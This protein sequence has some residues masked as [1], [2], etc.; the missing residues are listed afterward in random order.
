MIATSHHVM[1]HFG[2]RQVHVH[3]SSKSSSQ[4][5]PISG[6][7]ASSINKFVVI[8]I[9][10][11]LPFVANCGMVASSRSI[12][13]KIITIIINPECYNTMLII[14]FPEIVKIDATIS[15]SINTAIAAI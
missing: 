11:N 3:R 7:M 1:L 6:P 4:M 9:L 2:T 5:R 8:S 13:L 12:Y 15:N 14:F 10:K